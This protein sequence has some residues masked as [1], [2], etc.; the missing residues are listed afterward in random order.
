MA[1]KQ[2]TGIARTEFGWRAFIRVRGTLYS[3]RFPPDTTLTAMRDWRAAKRTDVLRAQFVAPPAGVF[4][5]DVDAYLAA[6]K[7]MPSYD[8]RER[9]MEAWLTI[10]GPART[11]QSITSTEIR[12]ALQRWRTNGR[13]DGKPLSESAC[14]HRRSALM[15]FFTVMNGKSGANPCRDVPKF[16]EPEPMPRGLPIAVLKRVFRCMPNS[17]TKARVLVMTFTGIPRATLMRMTRE[18]IDY[19][20]KTALVPRRRKGAGTTMR[21]M[22]LTPQA[23]AAFKLLD[24]FDGWGH[25]SR[26]SLLQSLHRAC[27]TA[28]VTPFRAYDLRHS[29][30]DATYE[31]TG[32]IG[33]VQ[34]LLDHADIKMTNRYTV[35]AIST[36]LKKAVGALAKGYR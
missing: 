19:R 15:H 25:F 14:N 30:A 13:Q 27:R 33:A 26:A 24:R 9:D 6:V 29:I 3:Q 28:G 8:D 16:R 5:D 4:R 11:R 22:P 10:I 1:R 12:A 21:V 2:N 31:L 18:H 20:A 23:V 32:D 36:R 7:T 35:K 17:K 34:A